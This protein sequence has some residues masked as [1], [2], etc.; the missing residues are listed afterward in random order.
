MAEPSGSSLR[1]D[2]RIFFDPGFLVAL[3]V[4]GLLAAAGA[5]VLVSASNRY[6]IPVQE[7]WR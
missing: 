4:I 7:Y 1:K 3:L 6:G 5:Y 2:L